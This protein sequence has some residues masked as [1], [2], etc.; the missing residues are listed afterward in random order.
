MTIGKKLSPILTEIENALWEFEY[1]RPNERPKY[2]AEGFRG[3]IKIFMS[4]LLDKMYQYQDE[5]SLPL[6]WRT[7]MAEKAGKEIKKLVAEYTGINTHNLYK[8]TKE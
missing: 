4:A 1:N 2:S 5:N 8:K 6:K 7:K 3:A